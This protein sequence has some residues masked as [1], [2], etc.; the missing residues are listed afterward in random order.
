MPSV[1]RNRL[2]A[3]HPRITASRSI[4]C[5]QPPRHPGISRRP[6]T[7]RRQLPAAQPSRPRPHHRRRHP[8]PRPA[9]VHHRGPTDRPNRRRH[10]RDGPGLPW[11][12]E[13]S[14][15]SVAT[16]ATPDLD[17]QPD[18][19]AADLSA[20]G[21]DGM[22]QHIERPDAALPSGGFRHARWDR[23][24]SGAVSHE[25][26]ETRSAC[27]GRGTELR[28]AHLMLCPGVTVGRSRRGVTVETTLPMT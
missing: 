14:T 13:P 20:E 26:I 12:P 25:Y 9:M 11:F 15:P 1:T 22:R 21:G 2:P 16:G 28:C 10:P 23:E 18:Q 24:L 7:A 8:D 4:R 27:I 3:R 19:S 17:Q 6:P 5:H